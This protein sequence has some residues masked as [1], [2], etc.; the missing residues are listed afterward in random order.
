MRINIIKKIN[1]LSRRYCP[2]LCFCFATA[3]LSQNPNDARIDALLRKMTLEEKV[4]QMAQITLDVIGKG[5]NRFASFEPFSLDTAAARKA[6][7]TYKVG[8]VL[9]T[10]NNRAR[11]TE[12]WFNIING[13]Q[14]IA[15]KETRLAIPVIYGVDAVH[16]VTYTAGATMFPQQIAQA[17]TFNRS[18]VQK[19][20]AITAYETRAS[21]IPWN[22]SPILDLGADPRFPRQWESFG[23]DP[24][25][26]TELGKE[27]IKGYEGDKNAI[28]NPEKVASSNAFIR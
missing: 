3:A 24:Y 28:S 7:V 15:V 1:Y 20:A 9:N 26:V 22:F 6:L 19:A 17:A 13:I 18:F 23:E 11:T 10:A 25:L 4:G 8:S 5:K 21:G 2:L 12:A 14:N 27:M 16:G